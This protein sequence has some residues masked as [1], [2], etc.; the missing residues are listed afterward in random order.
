VNQINVSLNGLNSTTATASWDN[1]YVTI[2]RAN[3]A[4]KYLPGI[5]AL[6]E[7]VRNNYLAQAYAIR[8]YM[9]FFLV[10]LWGAAPVRLTAYENISENPDLPRSSADSI[11]KNVILPDLQ[12]ALT[13]ANPTGT[14][15]FE[16]NTGGILSMLTEVYMWQKDYPKVLETTDKLIGLNRY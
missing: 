8:A 4:I 15:V 14:S 1:I 2:S 6:N 16:V 9:Y 10:R 5:S 3:F 12:K 13:L 7:T 11:L